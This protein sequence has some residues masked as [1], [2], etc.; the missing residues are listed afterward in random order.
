MQLDINTG[1]TTPIGAVIAREL[2]HASSLRMASA[3]LS[4]RGLDHIGVQLEQILARS[5][6]VAVLHGADF[7]AT[8][9]QS[10]K[11]LANLNLE[12]KSMRYRVRPALDLGD[13]AL[14]HPKMYLVGQVNGQFTSVIGSSNATHQ[15]FYRNVEVNVVLKGRQSDSAIKQSLCTFDSLM[16]DSQ[17]VEPWAEWIA[18]YEY[19]YDL[20]RS[21]APNDDATE[22]QKLLED[23]RRLSQQRQPWIP[24]SQVDCVVKALQELE[25]HKPSAEAIHLTEIYAK[26][27][28]V[29]ERFEIEYDWSALR[30]SVRGRINDNCGERGEQLFMRLPLD[31]SRTG[32]YRLSDRGRL[33][34]R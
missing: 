33:F 23:L 15:G 24:Q 17:L 28:E 27:K 25:E 14:F 19:I 26:T 3:Y 11:R 4:N 8:D 7:R 21:R 1:P 32:L 20:N 16:S 22:L 12:Y 30:S 6:H 13:S 31:S 29:A 10:I 5:G 2:Q 9:P 18:K 34:S